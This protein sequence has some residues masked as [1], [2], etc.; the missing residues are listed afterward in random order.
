MQATCSAVMR[1][2]NDIVFPL[3]PPP[4]TRIADTCSLFYVIHMIKIY[5]SK[6][7]LKVLSNDR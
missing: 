2:E 1:Y 3:C 5:Y 6:S 4:R 7:E